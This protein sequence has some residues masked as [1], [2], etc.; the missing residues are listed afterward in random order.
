[1][2]GLWR[3]G[4]PLLLASKSGARRALLSAAGLPFELR[5]ASIDERSLEAPL[6]AAG[7]GGAKVAR[8]LARAK[9]LAIGAKEAERLVLGADQTLALGASIFAKPADRASA[10]AQLEALSGRTHE[11][12]SAICIVRGDKV[13]FEAAP[14]ARLTMRA[15][16]RPFID[17]Y[18][19][20]AGEAVLTSV[21]GYQI[22]GLG[23][24][25]FERV[26]GDQSTILGLPL[27]PLLSFLREEGSLLG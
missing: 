1:M 25:L 18:V 8:E 21:G 6:L 22:E 5:P 19:A 2:T 10:A 26:E 9:A 23:V 13:L 11:L 24:H 15:L 16:S 17:A 27:L 14:A 12:H 4:A 20:L 3:G 7:A